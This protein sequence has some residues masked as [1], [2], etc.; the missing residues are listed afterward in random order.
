[1]HSGD[2]LFGS[3]DVDITPSHPVQLYGFAYRENALFTDVV[4]GLRL[5]AFVFR[6]GERT[7]CLVIADVLWWP[8]ELIDSIRAE[9]HSRWGIE[10]GDLLLSATH[11]HSAPATS[12][13]AHPGIGVVDEEWLHSFLAQMHTAIDTAMHSLQPARMA[14]YRGTS[15][16]SMNRRIDKGV[17]SA[18]S[19]WPEG[20][21]DRELTTLLVENE[22]GDPLAAIIHFSCHPTILR[23]ALVSAEFPG[24]VCDLVREHLGDA[25]TVGF[26]QGC[27]GDI[28]PV[29]T[30]SK[31][32]KNEDFEE[33]IRL[34]R[35]LTADVLESLTGE[36]EAITPVATAGQLVPVALPFAHLPSTADLEEESHREDYNGDWARI[37]L[38]RGSVPASAGL[39]IQHFPLGTD[40]ALVAM[41]GEIV[42]RYGLHVKS[43]S[44]NTAL[45][46][47]Y[48]NGMTGYI[49]TDQQ[50]LNGGYESGESSRWLMLPSR[51]ALGNEARITSA[52]EQLLRPTP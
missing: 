25:C 29:V 8:A 2:L 18:T 38:E 42:S 22:Q 16:V 14:R 47:G 11:T 50:Q 33:V 28:G 40:L 10:P 3:A 37:L 48:S 46:C 12:R 19:A 9:I 24:V 26:L 4:S 36:A 43:L 35:L 39:E 41:N 1:M 34:G 44:D 52:L 27:C 5:K 45:A 49:V 20:E 30:E 21:I 32:G 17:D 13:R 31:M 15:Q 6:A 51:F 23:G 7:R